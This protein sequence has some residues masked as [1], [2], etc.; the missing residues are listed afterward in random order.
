MFNQLLIHLAARHNRNYD[1]PVKWCVIIPNMLR[2]ILSSISNYYWGFG[3]GRFRKRFSCVWHTCRSFFLQ[4]LKWWLLS[5]VFHPEF[6]SLHYCLPGFLH[7][8]WSS[9]P[10]SGAEHW[11]ATVITQ[12]ILKWRQLKKFTSLEAILSFS[13]G[14]FLH[15]G[16]IWQQHFKIYWKIPAHCSIYRH[17]A[18][19]HL[20]QSMLLD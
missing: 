7:C 5:A 12:F 15:P 20:S 4:E 18:R 14:G 1:V 17:S 2:L 3:T 19:L 11:R 6:H 10:L 8:D 9:S 13:C 16:R